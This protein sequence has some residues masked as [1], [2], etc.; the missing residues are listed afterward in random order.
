M[1][2]YRSK[3]D[4]YG[5]KIGEVVV[6]SYYHINRTMVVSNGTDKHRFLERRI[7]PKI[8][9]Q[10]HL[11][12]KLTFSELLKIKPHL[13]KTTLLDF[14]ISHRKYLKESIDKFTCM[15]CGLNHYSIEVTVDTVDNTIKGLEHYNFIGTCTNCLRRKVPLFLSI[16]FEEMKFFNK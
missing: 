13:T 4:Q 6:D 3:N 5:L 2:F 10:D 16:R 12:T 11:F 15:G 8:L 7:E 14:S 9:N 1:E